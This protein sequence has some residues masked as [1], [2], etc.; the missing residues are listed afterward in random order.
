MSANYERKIVIV[1]KT[2]NGKSSLGNVL[3]RRRAFDE[4]R[5][6][7]AVT[8]ECKVESDEG[9]VSVV[10]TPGLF[11]S[12]GERSLVMQALEIQKAIKLCPNPHAFLI[13]LNGSTRLTQEELSTVDVLRIIFGEQCLKKA[14]I[15]LTHIENNLDETQ[16]DEMLDEN[17]GMS[18]L[19]KLCENRF[20]RIDN[21]EPKPEHIERINRLVDKVSRAG[22]VRF[23][24]GFLNVHERVFREALKNHDSGPV[25]EQIKRLSEQILKAVEEEKEFNRKCWKAAGVGAVCVAAGIAYL[26][27]DYIVVCN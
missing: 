25:H 14:I 24:N 16:L 4:A 1:G 3:L 21:R 8:K 12:D 17:S 7:N 22:K 20:A 15:V 19:I 13:V 11:D 18:S 27:N 10:D 2:G 6:F 23:K 26:C 9:N 5:S